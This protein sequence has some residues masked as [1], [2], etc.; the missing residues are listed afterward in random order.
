VLTF[1]VDR[2]LS[3]WLLEMCGVHCHRQKFKFA[4]LAVMVATCFVHSDGVL[5]D[6][7]GHRSVCPPEVSR[8]P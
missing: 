7:V 6:P 5:V 1:V 8:A 4:D 3:V 2:V